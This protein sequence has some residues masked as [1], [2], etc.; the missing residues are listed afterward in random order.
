MEIK[1]CYPI[2][3][4]EF[5]EYFKL[6]FEVLRRPWNEPEGSE[7]DELEESSFHVCAKYNN[8][9]IGACRLQ[10]LDEHK[11]RAQIR[12]MCTR[13]DFQGKGIGKQMISFAEDFAKRNATNTI[14]LHARENA[15][16]F[17]K[18]CGYTVIEPSYLLFGSI[19]HFLMEKNL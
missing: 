5:K 18:S 7:K 9:I 17:Y 4:D 16:N 14:I 3:A 13:I 11:I 12:Y 8:S 10:F 1:I 6:R 15:V 2:T 19:P